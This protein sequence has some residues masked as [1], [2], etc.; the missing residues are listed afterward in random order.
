MK[1]NVLELFI[2]V[3]VPLSLKKSYFNKSWLT[4]GILW[5]PTLY[6]IEFLVKYPWAEM[7]ANVAN[8]TNSK[9]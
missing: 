4:L 8:T 3:H 9:N 6:N 2:R 7:R 1:Y 5:N